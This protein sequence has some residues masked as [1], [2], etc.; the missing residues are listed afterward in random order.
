MLTSDY[1]KISAKNSVFIIYLF[2]L[3]LSRSLAF[4]FQISCL[5]QDVHQNYVLNLLTLSILILFDGCMAQFF[6]FMMA[7]KRVQRSNICME[8]SRKVGLKTSPIFRR[9]TLCRLQILLACWYSY[10]ET[11]IIVLVLLVLCLYQHV[12]W[13]QL[14]LTVAA[15][16]CG[17]MGIYLFYCCPLS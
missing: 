11:S 9:Y 15:M 5:G 8:Q 13:Q 6:Y 2:S 7:Q 3:K 17:S 14:G 12:L 1:K 16:L 4:A 10:R